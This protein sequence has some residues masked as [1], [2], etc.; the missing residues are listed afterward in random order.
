MI[1][2]K[3]RC[4]YRRSERRVGKTKSVLSLWQ[5]NTS[6]TEARSHLVV[7]AAEIT[8]IHGCLLA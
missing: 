1:E 8:C 4:L 2:I 5:W 7:V 3:N 6:A